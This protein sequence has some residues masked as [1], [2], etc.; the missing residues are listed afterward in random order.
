MPNIEAIMREINRDLVPE[1]EKKLRAYLVEQDK[2]WLIEQIIRLTLDA[3]SLEEMDRKHIHEEESQK[4]Y[5]RAE[6]VKKLELDKSK[7]Q[8]FVKR[9][10]DISRDALIQ[11]NLLSPD[12]PAKGTDLITDEFRT[13]EGV[14]LLQH[15]KDMLFGL[16]FGDESTNTRFHR[17]RRKLLTL[18]V[19]RMKSDM[20]DFMKATTELN[21]RGTWQDPKGGDKDL[22]TD[23][24]ILEIEY[25]ETED[26]AIGHGIITALKLINNLEVNE[27]ILYGRM[28]NVERSTLIS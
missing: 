14:A 20:L 15:A 8:D 6:R 22:R 1:F 28:E 25:G 26:E 19:P 24:V 11:E 5:E 12:A 2:D 10:Q 13:S 16:L 9:H 27:E 7:L 21:A 17:T 4:R 23:N 3:H 18:T